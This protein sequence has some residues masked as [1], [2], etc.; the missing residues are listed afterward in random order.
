MIET[1]LRTLLLSQSGVTSIAKPQRVDGL[2]FTGVFNEVA[3]QGCVP[4]FV[5]IRKVGHNP[6]V[7]LD[8][9]GGLKLTDFEI[10]ACSRDYPE[11]LRLWQNMRDF[12]FPETEADYTGNA[13]PEDTIEAVINDG[14][15]SS[16]FADDRA[17]DVWWYI[18]T[19]R[20]QVQH[21]PR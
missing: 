19:L 20:I 11:A 2:T 14:R 12:F 13:G 15:S 10:D 1:G 17:N 16:F 8:G 18:E 5:V 7:T 6:L 3:V 9:A 4:P 21:K